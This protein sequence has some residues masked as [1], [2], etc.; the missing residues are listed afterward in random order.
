[1]EIDRFYLLLGMEAS[2]AGVWK[3]FLA[4]AIHRYPPLLLLR[5][6]NT[7]RFDF[8]NAVFIFLFPI[9]SRCP[10]LQHGDCVLYRH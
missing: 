3:L 1:M 2:E 5:C 9:N 8:L 7:S 10:T 6:D 4:V